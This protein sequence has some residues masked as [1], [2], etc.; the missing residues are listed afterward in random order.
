MRYSLRIKQTSVDICVIYRFPGRSVND[1][2]SELA[3]EIE[4][5]I[6]LT[7]VRCV[8]IGHCNIHVDENNPETTTFNDF[9]ESFNLKKLVSFPTHIHILWTSYWMI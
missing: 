9:M 1:F 5:N 8:Y 7:S 4:E 2:C 6:N 3:S